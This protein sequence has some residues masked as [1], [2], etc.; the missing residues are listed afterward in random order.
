ML[1]SEVITKLKGLIN[2]TCDALENLGSKVGL[3]SGVGT[4]AKM[5]IAMYMM[6]L[7]ASDGEIKWEEA[8]AISNLCDLSLTP[9]NVGDFIREKN[10]YSTEFESKVPVSFDLAV[11]GDN[12]LLQ[13][14]IH[15]DETLSELMISTY[16]YVGEAL[17]KSDDNVDDN[18]VGDY[19]I[20]ISMLE[21]YRDKN[22]EGASGVK[23]FS[24]QG[25]SSVAAPSKS[26]V[27]APRKG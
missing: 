10:I 25:S 17:I 12:L 15:L 18:E 26:G 2:A 16:K 20:Y 9:S 13:Q 8:K 23:G 22:Y 14:G 11:K 21:E 19:R 24:K 3:D 5:E 27:A 6:Y 7:S 4:A 1:N